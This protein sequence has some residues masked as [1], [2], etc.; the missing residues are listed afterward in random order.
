[1]FPLSDPGD[2][3]PVLLTTNMNS[4]SVVYLNGSSMPNLKSMET[5]G[6][7]IV[8][9][10]YREESLCWLSVAQDTGQLWCARMT[11]LKVFSEIHEIRIG[12]N[13]QSE[14]FRLFSKCKLRK[15]LV[16]LMF[17]SKQVQT[18]VL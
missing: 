3:P 8:D 13:L 14:Y 15:C 1:M 6:T 16:T 4:I 10:I 12:Q 18:N 17:Y 2:K 7:Q 11:K 5:N 9:F